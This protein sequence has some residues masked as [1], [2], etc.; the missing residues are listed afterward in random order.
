MRAICVAQC[1]T[2]PA[3]WSRPR[4]AP[5]HTVGLGACRHHRAALAQWGYP[6]WRPH[7]SRPVSAMTSGLNGVADRV[8]KRTRQL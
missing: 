2:T 8:R 4:R 1:I 3:L 5:S 6:R 7:A